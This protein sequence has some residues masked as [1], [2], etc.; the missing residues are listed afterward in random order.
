[1]IFFLILQ[2]Y[3]LFCFYFLW[4]CIYELFVLIFFLIGFI[5]LL[6]K[7]I[8]IYNLSYNKGFNLFI[9]KL[10]LCYVY[11]CVIRLK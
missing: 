2:K 11:M 5:Y 7:N 8:K 1:M 6:F 3:V 4:F 10:Y 9:S